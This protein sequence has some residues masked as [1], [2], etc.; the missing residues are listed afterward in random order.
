MNA[1]PDPKRSAAVV[2]GVGEYTR[3][4]ELPAV[5]E[6]R[7]RL[8][9]VLTDPEIWGLPEGR[10]HEV[11]DPMH[12][13]DLIDP[14]IEAAQ[15]ARDT[16][17]VYYAGHGFI[18]HKGE[19]FLTLPE[20]RNRR[21]HTAVPYD[22]LRQA[23]LE[24]SG[25]ERRVVI[26]DCCYSGR[27][28]EG[29]S[30]PAAELPA[31]AG[32]NGSYLLTS[33]AE[34]VQA[35]SPRGEDCTAFTGE[36]TR[37]LREGIPDGEEFLTLDAVYG[38]VLH[39][40]RDKGRPEPQEQDRGQIG[41]LPFVRN[42][43]EGPPPPPP[44][45]RQGTVLGVATATLLAAVAVPVTWKLT[46]GDDRGYGGPCSERVS[47]LGFSDRLDK[48][49]YHGEPVSGL[50]SLAPRGGSRLLALSDTASPRLYELSAKARGKPEPHILDSTLLRRKD[51]T[52]YSGEDFDAEAMVTEDGGRTVLV[53]S[54][55]GPSI[56]RFD[57][58]SGR[59]VTG[60]PVPERFR[61]APDGDGQR[62][63]SFESMALSPDG[64]YLYVG[65]ESPL[66]GDGSRQGRAPVRILRYKGK[67]GGDYVPDR[68][69]AYLTGSGL[70]L[71]DLV[72][73]GEDGVLLA[74]ERGYAEGQGNAVRMH[75]VSLRDLPD[76]AGEESLAEAPQE[77][78]ARK[79]TLFDL[80]ECPD[81]G[82][83]SPQKQSN[84]LL[85][86]V[87]GAALGPR[88]TEGDDKGRRLLYLV[89]DDN[90]SAMQVTRFYALAVDPD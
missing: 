60:F 9:A 63:E 7:E 33:A 49:E 25:A 66:S 50:S 87:E 69:F 16:L 5:K 80:A 75:R 29:M 62:S 52:A 23:I 72:A 68:Q 76:V 82:A 8:K 65:I 83:R 81:S 67:P 88:L 48:T 28:L 1:L 46:T 34:N 4:P 53:A 14:V 41:R 44:R 73:T 86:N 12:A 32:I 70:R 55:S 78:F 64:R 22:W 40:L 45:R 89:S 31:A 38:R 24:H 56:S 79:R 61:I 35:L 39:A 43:A 57:V 74:L 85:D 2:V 37:V 26:L 51:G 30:D 3:M 6:N 18:D 13:A 47:L 36:L 54:E 17:I 10:F 90:D 15:Q 71:A 59:L 27:A 58:G 84:P 19:L 42:R 20:S 21:R 77:A 11:P